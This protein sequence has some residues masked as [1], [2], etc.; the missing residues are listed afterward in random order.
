M[1]IATWNIR[2]FGAEGKK[3]MI[4]SLIKEEMLE[5]IGL[6]ETKHNEVSDWKVQKCWGQSGANYMHVTTVN[7][8]G[9]LLVSWHQEAFTLHNSFAKERWLCVV[10]EFHKS[11][12]KCAV[13]LV[14]APNDHQERLIVWDQLR[15]IR[16]IIEVP[17]VLM[18]DFNEVLSP[19]ERQGGSGASQGMCELQNLF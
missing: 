14:Y 18:G 1:K 17:M 6:V 16:S 15:A 7:G 8:S 19:T 11:G 2:G 5:L 9:G 12:V 4:K 3:H 10:G 13:C